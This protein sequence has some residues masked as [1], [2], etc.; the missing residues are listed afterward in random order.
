MQYL[1]RG[2]TVHLENVWEI[3]KFPFLDI[4]TFNSN[5]CQKDI[6]LNTKDM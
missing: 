3:I 6:V 4:F 2:F 5:Y 1:P